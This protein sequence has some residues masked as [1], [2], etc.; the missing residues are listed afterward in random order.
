MRRAPRTSRFAALCIPP[1]DGPGESTRLSDVF[2]EVEESLRSERWKQLFLRWWPV[3]A[4]IVGVV[5]LVVG[6][7]WFWE[8][9]KGW[10]AAEAS[11]AYQRGI[12]ALQADNQS[13]AEA[14]FVEVE[15]AGNPAYRALALMQRAG[16]RVERG[17]TDEAVAL[18]DQ[19]A[20]VTNEPLIADIAR[21]KAAWALMDTGSLEDITARLSPLTEEGRPFRFQ[22]QEALALARLQHGQADAARQQ[23]QALSLEL[24][25]PESMRQRVQ[26]TLSLIESGTASSIPGIVEAAANAAAQDRAAAEAATAQ[27]P[28]AG[29]PGVPAAQAPAAGAPSDQ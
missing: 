18:F 29:A 20:D 23:L 1:T 26:V 27:R 8:A 9:R 22:A 7:I 10:T 19:A 2:E 17:E 28:G 4:A 25:L 21:L 12:E 6:G 13:A 16:L 14:A 5:V 24:E 15:D 3:A 11:Q